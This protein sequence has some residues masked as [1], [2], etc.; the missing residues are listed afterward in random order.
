[1][2]VSLCPDSLAVSFLRPDAYQY[3]TPESSN[4]MK[5]Y[6]KHSRRQWQHVYCHYKCHVTPGNTFLISICI[7]ILPMVQLSAE[8]VHLATTYHVNPVNQWYVHRHHITLNQAPL[9]LPSLISLLLPAM[10]LQNCVARLNISFPSYITS[11]Y[12]SVWHIPLRLH[13]NGVVDLVLD[14][15]LLLSGDIETNPGPVGQFSMYIAWYS[16]GD[17]FPTPTNYRTLNA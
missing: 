16:R 9:V 11:S 13:P 12:F 10:V 8:H 14:L 2:H 5:A 7:L 6:Q 1:M 17:C 4:K 3:W 15:L